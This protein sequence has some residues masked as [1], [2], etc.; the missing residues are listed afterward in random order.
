MFRAIS[1]A[2]ITVYVTFLSKTE[3]VVRG[4]LG[5]DPEFPEFCCVNTFMSGLVRIIRQEFTEEDYAAISRMSDADEF[6]KYVIGRLRQYHKNLRN[7]PENA[8]A[9]REV[10]NIIKALRQ[11]R[12]ELDVREHYPMSYGTSFGWI[13]EF[14]KNSGCE[15][16]HLYID[17]ELGLYSESALEGIDH[18]YVDSKENIS[19]RVCDHIA[20]FVSKMLRAIETEMSRQKMTEYGGIE[21]FPVLGAGWFE[22]CEEAY[23]TYRYIGDLLNRDGPWSAMTTSHHDVNVI[24]Y[25]LLGYMADYEDFE[26]YSAYPPEQH[27]LFFRRWVAE[28]LEDIQ[29]RAFIPELTE[30]E[31]RE[32]EDE[33]M[34]ELGRRG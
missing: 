3:T 14:M 7:G 5:K 25:L 20:G 1:A 12:F 26:E 22:L 6:K 29:M 2:N 18:D 31:R 34:K 10:P 11:T 33:I 17:G 13:D 21:Y 27:A 16:Y 24:L 32:S 9:Q 19:V 4:L 23:D 28:G 15:R 8:S 30:S